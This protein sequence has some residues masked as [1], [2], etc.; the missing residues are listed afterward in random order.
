MTKEKIRERLL[1]LRDERYRD[2]NSA[3][4]PT[5]DKERLIG[6]RTPILRAFAKELIKEGDCEEF[7][8]ALPHKYYEE[9]NLHG[10]IIEGIK[11]FDICI[12]ELRRFIP[13]IDNWATCDS[14]RPKVLKKEPEKLLLFI[15]ELLKSKE[16]Y[17]VRFGIGLLLSFYLD[18]SFSPEHLRLVSQ[19]KSE[20]YYIN[21]MISWYFAT[22]LAKQWESTVPYLENRLL[23]EWVHRKTIQKA[24]ESYRITDEEKAYLKSL[25]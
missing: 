7:L 1:S 21:M 10:F 17:T 19:I 4:I 13:Y 16:T 25:K 20:E 8:S 24:T 5:A 12:S 9:N 18:E 3:L 2:F 6:I 23:S 15:K 22:A 14:V 11:D